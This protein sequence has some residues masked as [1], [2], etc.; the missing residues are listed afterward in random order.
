V[1]ANFVSALTFILLLASPQRGTGDFR[2]LSFDPF[3]IGAAWS[4]KNNTT[5]YMTTFQV[6]PL[7]PQTSYSCFTPAASSMMV[8]IKVIKTQAGAYWNPGIAQNIDYYVYKSASW[9]PFIFEEI[10]SVMGNPSNIVNTTYFF[11]GHADS[12]YGMMERSSSTFWNQAQDTGLTN[13]CH[14]YPSSFPETW[15]TAMS[16]ETR[17]TPVYS[18]PV[19]CALYTSISTTQFQEKWCFAADPKNKFPPALV[20]LDVLVSAGNSENI[21]LQTT[22]ITS[23]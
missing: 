23:F 5:G 7:S 9:G 14:T 10:T 22:Q 11:A 2:G 12:P 21:T 17:S 8:D 19:N 6:L 1:F 4:M 3:P 18:G 16:A 13:T 20:E 15:S